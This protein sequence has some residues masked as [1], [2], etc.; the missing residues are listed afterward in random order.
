MDRLAYVARRLLLVIP[1][2][3]GITLVCFT[4]T[5]FVP[6]GPVEMRMMRLKGL[7]AQGGGEAGGAGSSAVGAVSDEYRK[8]LEAQYGFDR[9]LAVQY[10]DWLVVKKM[11]MELPSYDYP[12]KT[13]WQL[14]KSRIPISL[15]FGL[16]SFILT[17][18]ICV[19]L[20]I[21]KAL[22]HRQA[23]DAVSS[24]VVFIAYAIPS[25]ALAMMLKM[26]LCGTVEGLGDV[27]PLG[28]VSSDFDVDPT[29]WVWFKDR[30]WHMVLP[31]C[32]YVAGSFAML[33][34]LMKNSLLDQI[35]A[36]YV[37]TVIAK[38]A[39][40]RRAIWLHA[41]RNALIP[42]ATGLGPMIGLLFAGSIIIESIFEIPGMGRLSWDA[43]I[44]RDYAV[45]LALLALT[46]SFQLVGN[47]ISDVLYMIIDPRIDFSKK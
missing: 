2:F 12:N 38:G 42:I 23:F 45:F 43:L 39:T 3:L 46:A 35:S 9:P 32:C 11:G 27:F 18:L 41:F 34:L 28:G 30:A 31:I 44:G 22:K 15:W 47:L 17:Y 14:I 6:G 13:A 29:W 1:T 4:L 16:A 7:A 33:T 19:P 36:D 24:L 40:R 20:G 5:R 37:R 21:A 26:F 10:W 25:F 8:Q